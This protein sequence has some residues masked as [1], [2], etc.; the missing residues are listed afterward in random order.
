MKKKFEASKFG[1]WKIFTLVVLVNEGSASVSEI[2]SGALQD[3]KRA[4]L[5][6]E[7][8]LEKGS[9]Q[10]VLPI[11]NEKNWKY[12]LTIAKYYLHQVE[13]QSKQRV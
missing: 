9:V 5:V 13:E 4:I 6:G 3:H 11:D 1:T 7:K 8:L 10:S 12:L 2:V